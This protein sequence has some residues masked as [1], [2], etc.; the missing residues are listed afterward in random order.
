VE[1][2]VEQKYRIQYKMVLPENEPMNYWLNF[3]NDVD[4]YPKFS[5]ARSYIDDF[6]QRYADSFDCP[7]IFRIFV[8][9]TREIGT[10]TLGEEKTQ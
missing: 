10:I 8:I 2:I 6:G 5:D 3:G 4:G 7:L 9:E 1:N